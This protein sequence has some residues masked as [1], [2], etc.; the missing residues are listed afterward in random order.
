VINEYI[1]VT[2]N[3]LMPV[4]VKLFNI[5]LN[6]GII[7][8]DWTIGLIKPLYKNKGPPGDPDNYRGI[9]ILSCFGKLF[10]ALI[11]SRTEAFLNVS[12]FIGPDQAGFKKG[13][14]TL[15][16]IFVLNCLIEMYLKKHK[17]LYCCFVDYKKAFDSVNRVELW[18]KILSANIN[19]RIFTVIF[20]LYQNAK[21]CVSLES[22]ITNFFPCNTGVRQGENLS[23]I[24][25][26]IFLIVI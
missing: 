15:D 24:L 5:V 2:A 4:Y 11:N 14:S 23:P 16:H 1:K 3:I 13:H 26:A 20:N 7:P 6:T 18:K 17:R 21:S 19:G 22:N 12:G 10:T 25:F 8:S 9:T